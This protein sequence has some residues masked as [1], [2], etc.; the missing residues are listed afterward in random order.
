MGKRKEGDKVRIRTDLKEGQR[1]GTN[2]WV[3]EMNQFKGKEVTIDY[4]DFGDSCY[5]G[6][7]IKEEQHLD[8]RHRYTEQMF[9][10]DEAPLTALE[11]L[12]EKHKELETLK[13]KN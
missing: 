2:T 8:R 9:Q 1:Y 10:D 11:A 12:K 3:K 7:R 6:Y 13:K 4:H 5:S